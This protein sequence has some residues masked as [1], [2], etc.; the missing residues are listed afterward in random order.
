MIGFTDKLFKERAKT[1]SSVSMDLTGTQ[2]ISILLV[3]N[4]FGAFGNFNK[5]IDNRSIGIYVFS[6]FAF[7]GTIKN[8]DLQSSQ[9]KFEYRDQSV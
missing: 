4:F 5:I 7:D 2:S 6:W 1:F 9:L 8:F 3:L